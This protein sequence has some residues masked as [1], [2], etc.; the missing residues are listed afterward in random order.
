M[1]A[2]YLPC[3]LLALF[4]CLYSNS[5]LYI[6]PTEEHINHTKRKDFPWIYHGR[7]SQS[8]KSDNLITFYITYKQS[9]GKASMPIPTTVAT[10]LI[11]ILNQPLIAVNALVARY[12][13]RYVVYM[14]LCINIALY[15]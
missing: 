1:V 2:S 13:H 11:I 7:Q 15:P 6:I 4:S 10:L 9:T 3:T 12:V 14:H 5:L 8:S